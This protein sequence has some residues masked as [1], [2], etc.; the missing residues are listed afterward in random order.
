MKNNKAITLIALVITIIVLLILAGITVA[1][2]SN[3]GLFESAKVAK[4]KYANSKEKE[5]LEIDVYSNEIENYI[6]GNRNFSNI[7]YSLNEQDTGLKW[8]DG[9]KIYQKTYTANNI[10]IANN[11]TEFANN[12]F[13]NIY[14]IL[15]AETVCIQDA[16]LRYDSIYASKS[17]SSNTNKIYLYCAEGTSEVNYITLR[18]TKISE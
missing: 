10:T 3:N 1:Q 11:G 7:S 12:D 13:S 5:D 4:E 17:K 18:Y 9:K 14:C 16:T 15:G 6:N 2:L 8:L